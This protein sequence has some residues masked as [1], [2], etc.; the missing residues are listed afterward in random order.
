MNIIVI[1]SN[2][3]KCLL[4]GFAFQLN[5]YWKNQSVTVI[6]DEEENLPF[7]FKFVSV[8]KDDGP[9]SWSQILYKFLKNFDKEYFALFFE[10][11]YFMD[12]VIPEEIE[13]CEQIIKTDKS[14]DKVWCGLKPNSYKEY[15]EDMLVINKGDILVSS[16]RPSIWK[17]ETILKNIEL[18]TT[19]HHFER[20]V[21][22]RN[23][24][25]LIHK[26]ICIFPTIDA[27]HHGRPQ[28]LNMSV[29]KPWPRYS[30]YADKLDESDIN[31]YTK[32]QRIFMEKNL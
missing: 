32:Y 16:L 2:K 30:L 29:I 20:T 14:I 12:Y 3:Y 26:N 9:K 7:N 21:K 19:P 25:S 23:V 6:G 8:C 22:N 10:D 28:S 11:Q 24:K 17:T 13:K 4:P 18:N 1:T 27:I 31:I 5:K 15:N